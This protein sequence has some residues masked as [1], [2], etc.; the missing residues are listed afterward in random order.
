MAQENIRA[1]PVHCLE[2][3]AEMPRSGVE[4]LLPAPVKIR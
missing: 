4:G 3:D 1:L 2:R